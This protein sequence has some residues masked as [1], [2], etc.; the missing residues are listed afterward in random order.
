MYNLFCICLFFYCS[1][2]HGQQDLTHYPLRMHQHSLTISNEHLI[3]STI[4]HPLNTFSFVF[5][6]LYRSI[7]LFELAAASYRTADIY[8]YLSWKIKA[9]NRHNARSTPI[10]SWHLNSVHTSIILCTQSRFSICCTF[11]FLLRASK[12]ADLTEQCSTLRT[13][14]VLFF[15]GTW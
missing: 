4:S 15:W 5:L 1:A 2:S 7:Q 3:R 8:T 12:V 14:S 6:I 10:R 9:A 13:T 11:S